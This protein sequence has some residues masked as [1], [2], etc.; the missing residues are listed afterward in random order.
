MKKS[1]SLILFTVISAL[2]ADL[3][4]EN[5]DFVATINLGQ[6]LLER[7]LVAPH[8]SGI[9][10]HFPTAV[11][12]LP[13]LSPEEARKELEGFERVMLQ[14]SVRCTGQ[15]YSPNTGWKT[16]ERAAGYEKDLID[17]HADWQR[18][19]RSLAKFGLKADAEFEWSRINAIR[20]AAPKRKTLPSD[21]LFDQ[22]FMFYKQ[23]AEERF[24][25]GAQI[26]LFEDELDGLLRTAAF[27][28]SL[29]GK[30]KTLETNRIRSLLNQWRSVYN[31]KNYV[32][33]AELEQQTAERIAELKKQFFASDGKTP[34]LRPGTSFR[35]TGVFGFGG[36]WQTLLNTNVRNGSIYLSSKDE[37]LPYES[38]QFEWEVS[39]DA[40]DCNFDRYELAGGS[41]T[42][43][44]RKNFYKNPRTG[45]E[46]I[47]DVYWSSLAP[48]VLFDAHTKAVSIVESSLGIP[49]GPDAVAGVFDGKAR[50]IPRG[51]AIPS[52]RMSEGWLLLLWRENNAPKLPVLLFFEHAPDK[53]EWDGGGL[54][55]VRAPEVGRYAAATLYGAAARKPEFG[56]NW[57]TLPADVLSQC[58]SVARHLAYYPLDMDEFFAFGKNGTVRVWNKIREA[59]YLNGSWKTPAPA[60]VPFPPIYTLTD[61]IRPDQPLSASLMATRFGFYRTVSGDTISYE[62]SAPDLLERIV[63]KPTSGEEAYLKQLNDVILAD[64]GKNTRE[65]RFIRNYNSGQALGLAA[66][67]CMF[68]ADAKKALDQQ[69]LPGQL[70]LSISNEMSPGGAREVSQRARLADFLIDPNTGRAA[71]LAGWRGSNQGTPGIRGDMTLFNQ[72]PLFHAYG[73]AILFGRWNL[74]ER[75]WTKLKELYSAVDFNQPWRSPGMNTL[76]SGLIL[77]GDMYGDGFR[78]YNL[79]YRLARGMGDSE[80]ADRARYLAAKQNATTINVISPNVIVYNA[81]IKNI[82][83]AASPKSALGQLGVS[84]YGFR[85]APWTPYAKDAWNAPFQTIGCTNDYPFYGTLLRYCFD[86]SK[87]WLDTFAREIPEWNKPGYLYEQR[88]ERASNAWNYLKY[89]V[90][91]CRDRKAIRK[92]YEQTFPADYSREKPFFPCDAKLW[93]E[94]YWK[95][96]RREWIQRGNVLPHIIGQNDPLWIGDFGRARLVSGTY[97]RT[98]RLARIELTTERPDVL[99][100][101]SMVGPEQILRNG[102]TVVAKRGAWGCDYEIPLTAGN[103]EI[104]V[105]L[106]E[107]RVEDYP[108]PKPEKPSPALKLAK[109]PSPQKHRRTSTLPANFKVGLSSKLNLA[110]FC[111]RGFSDSP[112]NMVNKEFWNFPKTDVIRGIPFAFTDP[113]ENGGKGAIFLRGRYRK[114]FPLE[115]RG[116]PVNKVVKRIFFLHGM[117]YNADN[118]KTMTYRLNFADGQTR[119][120]DIYAGIGIGE[121]KVAPGGKS[122]TDLPS[123]LTGNVYPPL[124]SGQWGEG[125]GGYIYVWT[126]NVPALGVTNQDVDQRGLA[127]LATIDIISAGRAVP[128]VFAITVEE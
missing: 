40:E 120:I 119:E 54:R 110:P 20:D 31:R 69:R 78:C 56:V 68:S 122:L 64:K 106:P 127:K 39:F 44:K 18:N 126:S 104:T 74:V 76:S 117:C 3:A 109:A 7:K 62:L 9:K 80:L 95:L 46:E 41:W 77:Y 61:R 91:Y 107:F 55:I 52:N 115:I 75:H 30:R 66:G 128:I 118:G 70:D 121:W 15:P 29:G 100:L 93:E 97:D 114:E 23:I 28:E 72:T 124:R 67:F 101:V 111:T 59:V 16:G 99:T 38:A 26:I 53:L 11:Q 33:C 58:R 10:R 17:T 6:H 43:A 37:F 85:T 125:A 89:M 90:F 36:N 71:F 105:S 96:D 49:V 32:R 45:K 47:I 123:A 13:N 34:D 84:Q 103:N 108:F 82:P 65:N 24:R 22:A 98:A 4:Q 102:K 35:S 83:D 42:H 88:G 63:L 79:M 86:D 81:H 2:F 87:L 94:T 113:A 19:S 5:K 14:L 48:G 12:Q 1:L 60:Y 73:Q 21:P 25:L 8:F 50:L 92:L 57:K 51:T 27:R 112:D 116:I